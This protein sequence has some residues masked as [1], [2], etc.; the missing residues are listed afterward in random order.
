[1]HGVGA[2]GIGVTGQFRFWATGK[3]LTE[4]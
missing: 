4:R 3:L 1:M 2:R